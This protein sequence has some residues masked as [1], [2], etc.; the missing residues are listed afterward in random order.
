MILQALVDY[1]E[2]LASNNMISKPGYCVADVSYALNLSESCELLGVIPLKTAV[3]RGN[4]L[5][6]LPQPLE[7]PEQEKRSS[8]IKPCFMCDNSAYVLGVAKK[9]KP[10]R[11]KQCFEE[12][13]KL[14]HNI[15]DNVNSISAR[16]VLSFLDSW[17][18]EKFE[19]CEVLEDYREGLLSGGRIVFNIAGRGYAHEDPEIRRAWE[20]YRA[21][22]PD[23]VKMQCLVTGKIQPIARLHPNIKGVRGTKS[24]GASIV[25]FNAPAYESYGRAEQQGLNAPVSEYAAFAYTT[26]LNYLLSDTAHVQ[27]FGDTTVVYWA[28]S[29][30][31]IYRDI[32]EF[33]INPVASNVND[34]ID[35]TTEGLI[36]SIFRKIVEGKPIN[37]ENPEIDPYTRFYI[38]GLAPNAARISVRFFLED[39]FG[40][41]L[42][43]IAEHYRN[44]EIERSPDDF[45]FIP[46]WKLL[47]ETVSP[48]SSK[49]AASPLLS[50]S[51]LRSVFSGLPYPQ[52][53]YNSI[54][55]R[56]RAEREI[57]RAKAAI[58]KAFLI[59]QNYEKYKEELRVSL[60]ENSNN[61]A[62]LLGRLFAV[63][64]KAQLEANPGI[65]TTIKD[66]YF[67]SACAT[68][69][70][71]FPILLRLSNHHISKADYGKVYE[72]KIS[73]I[74]EKLDVDNNPFPASLN[75]EE[76]GIFIL[77][78]YHQQRANYAKKE[79]EVTMNE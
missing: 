56:V 51:V 32:F 18:P 45:E 47:L 43:N 6:E 54:I 63:L 74:M 75:L 13:R 5:Q 26:A 12:F 55:V 28:K 8:G 3:P 64:E 72:K 15:L 62:Y 38:L 57:T 49:K 24:M 44:L 79:K 21:G 2:I 37:E 23:A 40:N 53:L 78:Y 70:S 20:E 16:A 50:G 66:R 31:P 39:S 14:H 46:L 61:K 30:K 48:K 60:N 69:A 35:M 34:V 42:K 29:P 71:V 33:S 17:N 58:I 22:K 52:E 73:E 67:T 7:I 76:Q 59:K 25:S 11:V 27:F 41:I 65:N 9:D 19:E 68:P 4:R 1:Y 10:E 36:E 77:G